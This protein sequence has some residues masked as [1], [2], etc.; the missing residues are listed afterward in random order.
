MDKEELNKKVRGLHKKAV[1]VDRAITDT[2]RA[3]KAEAAKAK[4]KTKAKT[5]ATSEGGRT[6]SNEELFK[7]A[8]ANP[9]AMYRAS[10]LLREFDERQTY[11][12]GLP[13]LTDEQYKALSGSFVTEE[14]KAVLYKAN[15]IYEGALWYGQTIVGVR[16]KWQQ[17]AAELGVLLTKWKWYDSMAELAT[18]LVKALPQINQTFKDEPPSSPQDIVKVFTDKVF[19]DKVVREECQLDFDGE[20]YIA[21]IDGEGRLY[22]KIQ[23]QAETAEGELQTLRSAVEPFSNFLYSFVEFPNGERQLPLHFIPSVV[24]RIMEYPDAIDFSRDEANQK[25]FAYRLRQR[26][27]AGEAVTPLEEKMAVIPDYNQVGE[28]ELYIKRFTAKVKDCFGD[29]ISQDE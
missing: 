2:E 5:K 3:K 1:E 15:K 26:K 10:F 28:S 13:M 18:A 12:D 16:A 21:N 20:K 19:T 14:D 9:S 22:A 8:M 25:F 4:R 6:I 11:G 7:D 17:R 29:L 23:Q 24:E 27:E